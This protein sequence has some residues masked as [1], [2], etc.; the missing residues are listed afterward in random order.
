MLASQQVAIEIDLR[1]G[2]ASSIERYCGSLHKAKGLIQ[3]GELIHAKDC[4]AD[5]DP[6][7]AAR[8]D[9]VEYLTQPNSSLSDSKSSS[10]VG[11]DLA[12]NPAADDTRGSIFGLSWQDTMDRGGVL[13]SNEVDIV[14]D[15]E[16]LPEDP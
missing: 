13:V 9:F 4:G 14:I 8:F 15:V 10:S 2:P 5:C 16:A 6:P 12:D 7:V 11:V 1:E 3:C